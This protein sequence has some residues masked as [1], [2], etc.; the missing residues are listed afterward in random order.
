[1]LT[2]AVALLLGRQRN[3]ALMETQTSAQISVHSTLSL[4]RCQLQHSPQHSTFLTSP[5]P[6]D[7]ISE[8]THSSSPHQLL[9]DMSKANTRAPTKANTKQVSQRTFSNLS[10]KLKSFQLLMLAINIFQKF[11]NLKVQQNPGYSLCFGLTSVES[12]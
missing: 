2:L 1:M 12:T 9:Q 3:G 11:P 5:L 8:Q 10:N 4:L 6:A 7:V